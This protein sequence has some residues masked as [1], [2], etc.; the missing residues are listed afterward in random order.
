MTLESFMIFFGWFAAAAFIGV[1]TFKIVK[2]ATMPL[3]LRWEVYPVPHEAKEKRGYG[4]SYM[5]DVDWSKKPRAVSIVPEFVEM[6]AE[7]FALKKVKTYN[8]YGIW[9]FSM[10]M[11]W[12]IY[13]YLGWLLL[14]VIGNLIPLSALD[15]LTTVV[16]LASFILGT[17]GSLALVVKRMTNADLH[18]Y[19]APIDYF[20]LLFIASFFVTSLVSWLTH[21]SFAA[22]KAYIGS[23]L[24]LKPTA[25]PL[26][27]LLGFALF[28]LFM[29]YMPFTKLIHYFAKY[30]TFHHSLW[31]D[32][33]KVK[34]SVADKKIIAQLAYPVAWSAPHIV[35]GK[36]WLEQ[37]QNA[38]T[39]SGKK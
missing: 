3:N 31:D 6:G 19:T 2:V 5:E 32:A 23:V 39:E 34:G 38:A 25:V 33:F 26:T 7:I 17:F 37:A 21:F 10:A 16:G 30:F 24:F 13:L 8:V 36:T 20:N 28:E 9:V 27:V 1:S 15:I 11:H 4:G 18:L 35:A 29:V 14:L 22:H 12:G